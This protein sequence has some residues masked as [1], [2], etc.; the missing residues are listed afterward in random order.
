[1]PTET[2]QLSY[3]GSDVRNGAMDVYELAPALL[4]VGDL[5]RDA[6][7]FLNGDQTNINVKVESD[8][9]KGSFDIHLLLDQHLLETAHRAFPFASVVDAGGLLHALF[10]AA[11]EHGDKIVEGVV[12][13]LFAIYKLLKGEKP[14][15]GSITIG[16]NY[17]TV[18]IGDREV[19]VDA[20]GAQMYMNDAIRGD[21]DH[22][23]R[24]VA[25]DGIDKLEVLKDGKLL[26]DMTKDDLPLR[27]KALE[28]PQESTDQLLTD[29]REALVKVVTA[30]FEKGKW[31][32]SDGG[33]KFNATIADPVFQQKLDDRQEGFYKG[34]VLR[35]LIRTEQTEKANGKIQAQYTIQEVL[36]HRSSG[37]QQRLL[38][39]GIK[40]E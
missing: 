7:R 38:R 37:D 27:V 2:F 29:T 3:D 35:V 39:P 12:L 19:K 6:N 25:K 31:K 10:G 20:R 36:E 26:D 28:S 13:G 14:K 33:S 11:K 30:N 1:M 23:A 4:A 32:F 16:D 18:T 24:S 22:V 21:V 8:F 9:R 15:P 17:G 5:I 34:D 40:K